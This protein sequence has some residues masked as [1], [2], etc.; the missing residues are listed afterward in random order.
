MQNRGKKVVNAYRM[1]LNTCK[2]VK[3]QLL[4][5]KNGFKRLWYSKETVVN[6]YKTVKNSCKYLLN[7]CKHLENSKN[8]CKQMLNS[9]KCCKQ[10]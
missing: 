10:L 1:I 6:A 4:I 3:K 9:K 7:N 8:S 2:T 5:V